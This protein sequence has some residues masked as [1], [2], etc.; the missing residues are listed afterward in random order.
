MLKTSFKPFSLLKLRCCPNCSLFSEYLAF[1]HRTLLSRAQ[2]VLVIVWLSGS[3]VSFVQQNKENKGKGR[4]VRIK[5][6]RE[7]G[8][9]ED[10]RVEVNK[11]VRKKIRVIRQIGKIKR[12]RD[13]E[14]MDPNS[15]DV[16]VGSGSI[17]HRK[18]R[19]I[20]AEPISNLDKNKGKEFSFNVD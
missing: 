13:S 16:G 6:K 20:E 14:D 18:K 11:K 17:N 2:Y 9:Q 4:S 3:N 10:S 5:R 15:E 19:K 8:T 12:K 1:T 7:Y